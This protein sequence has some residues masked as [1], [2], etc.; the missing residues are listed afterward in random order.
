V[1]RRIIG[2]FAVALLSLGVVGLSS[3]CSSEQGGS[4]SA[5]ERAGTIALS[6]AA[7]GPAG[8]EYRLRDASFEISAYDGYS[9]EGGAEGREPLT[10][11]SEDDPNATSISVS[12]EEGYYGVRLKPGWRLEKSDGGNVTDVQA[13]LLSSETQGVY[14]YRRSSTTVAYEFGLGER[15]IWFNGK[16]NIMIGVREQPDGGV[17]GSPN[18]PDNGAFSGAS[19]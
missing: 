17:G 12:V 14:V 9:T 7:H 6:L 3:G 5:S 10:V 13:T 16:L 19:F 8:T 2:F 11:S 18:D 15:S 4:N 1:K